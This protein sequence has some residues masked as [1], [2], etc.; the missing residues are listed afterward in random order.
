MV[1]IDGYRDGSQCNTI[2]VGLSNVFDFH[3][4]QY[5][6]IY[7]P[8]RSRASEPLY[9]AEFTPKL[10]ENNFPK[11]FRKADRTESDDRVASLAFADDIILL[12]ESKPEPPS[13]IPNDIRIL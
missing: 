12:L 13:P 3:A 7:S 4:F 6:Q 2:K 8:L 5:E 1:E 9:L 11:T 10:F